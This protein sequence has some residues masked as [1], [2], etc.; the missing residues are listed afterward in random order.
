M[1]KVALVEDNRELRENMERLFSIFEEIKLIFSVEDGAEAIRAVNTSEVSPDVILMDIEMRDIDGIT[2]TSQIKKDHPEIKILMLSVFDQKEKVK[3][4]LSAGADGYLL[5]G[6][7]PMKI[8]DLIKEAVEGRLPMSPDIAQ[9]TRGMFRA[10]SEGNSGM[11]DFGLTRREKEV[12]EQL[13][14]GRTYQEIGE[15]LHISPLTVRTH[16]ENLYRK[17]KVHNKA[18]AIGL[19]LKNSWF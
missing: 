1:I 9:K 16:M 3:A 5:K 17:L 2:A 7:K 18:E 8:L 6:E 12:L 19:A 11:E 13:V 15:Y 4:A 10:A 14:I